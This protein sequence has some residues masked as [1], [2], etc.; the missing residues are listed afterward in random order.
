MSAPSSYRPPTE[1]DRQLVDGV[2]RER[3]HGIEPPKQETDMTKAMLA[4][5]RMSP[6]KVGLDLKMQKAMLLKQMALLDDRCAATHKILG[7]KTRDRRA[8]KLLAQAH[9]HLPRSSLSKQGQRVI[10]KPAQ[11]PKR[12]P[13]R[14]TT[15]S[16]T[17]NPDVLIHKLKRTA[18]TVNAQKIQNRTRPHKG[19]C[20]GVFRKQK[21]EETVFPT[22]Y[23]RGELP[24]AIEHGACHNTLSWACPLLQ[25]DYEHYLPIFLDG[26]RCT[27]ARYKFVARQGFDEMIEEAKGFPDCVLPVVPALIKPIR[28]A[29]A[30]HDPDIVVAGL[31]ALQK[32]VL[33]NYGVGEAMVP[34]YRQL[35]QPMNLFFTKRQNIGDQIFYGQRKG[36]DLGTAVLETLELLEKTGGPNAFVNIKSYVPVYESCM[37]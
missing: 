16:I 12:P 20:S 35:L 36:T 7:K 22:R 23:E 28:L 19:P 29:L 3:K 5:G 17:P 11:L 32:V 13:V 27:D 25:L 4:Q 18:K 24:C 2:W 31:N 1:Q 15:P 9:A 37:Q 26:I 8:H 21:V 14:R 33:S 6:Q 34:F 10:E 30:T